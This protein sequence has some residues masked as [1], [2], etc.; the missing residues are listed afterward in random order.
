[1]SARRTGKNNVLTDQAPRLIDRRLQTRAD[2]LLPFTRAAGPRWN[3]GSM[4]ASPGWAGPCRPANSTKKRSGDRADAGTN[5][6]THWRASFCARTRYP[7]APRSG[8]SCFCQVL[9][10]RFPVKP[11]SAGICVL[12]ER[13]A[14]EACPEPPK[15]SLQR[16]ARSPQRAKRWG[17]R[18]LIRK[19]AL[20]CL[21]GADRES[22]G[23]LRAAARC[24]RGPR[25]NAARPRC[26]AVTEDITP[27]S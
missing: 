5:Y 16:R 10:R 25:A 1:V 26:F 14:A 15:P 23:K 20:P 11:A 27:I 13:G 3:P 22:S 8:R 17:C 9:L 24:W 4:R 7:A 12:D 18:A 2:P 6:E 19:T 21:C